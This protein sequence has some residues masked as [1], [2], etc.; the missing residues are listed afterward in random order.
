M[1]TK[2]RGKLA[3]YGMMRR[4]SSLEKRVHVWEKK[5][6]YAVRAAVLE[7]VLNTG[8]RRMTRQKHVF[9]LTSNL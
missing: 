7:T 8:D 6:S 1:N 5:M 3:T 4:V 2:Q 9:R